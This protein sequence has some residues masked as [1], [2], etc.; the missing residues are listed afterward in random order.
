[1]VIAK[2]ATVQFDI[3]TQN[4]TATMK[5]PVMNGEGNRNQTS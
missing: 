2:D 4:G 5:V 3:N 1:M